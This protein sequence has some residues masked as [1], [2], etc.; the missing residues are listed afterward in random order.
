MRKRLAANGRNVITACLFFIILGPSAGL[1]QI[2]TGTIVGTVYDPSGGIVP[3][4]MV[5]ITDEGSGVT[6]MTKAAANGQYVMP[7]LPV[8]SYTLRV[9]ATGFQTFVQMG[10]ALNVQQRLQVDAHLKIGSTQQTV[11]VTANGSLL[12]TQS[13]NWG[14][15]V[16][17][18]EVSELP[19]NGRLRISLPRSG[20]TRTF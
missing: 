7:Y 16:N 15:I 2:S 1:A 20:S 11:S 9:T 5:R 13:A 6:R 14:Q 10:V 19:L 4:T 3:G 8:G 18:R 12:Q 17:S